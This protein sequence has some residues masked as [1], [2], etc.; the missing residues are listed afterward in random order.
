EGLLLALSSRPR[1]EIPLPALSFAPLRLDSAP[2]LRLA[3]EVPPGERAFERG[4][5]RSRCSRRQAE[6][7]SAAPAF[8]R[9][10]DPRSFAFPGHAQRREICVRELCSPCG[11]R[12]AFARQ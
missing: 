10:P 4:C 12:H 2:G 5:R 6:I 8:R 1:W 11:S 9:L 3:V 7:S